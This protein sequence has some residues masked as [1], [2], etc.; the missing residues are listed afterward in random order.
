MSLHGKRVLLTGG[1][2]G[3]GRA[4]AEALLVEGARLALVG[5]NRAAL[6]SL[7][8]GRVGHAVITGD[9]ARPEH[10]VALADQ[11]LRDLGGLDAFVSAAGIVEYA[12]V[13]AIAQAAI[14]R[15]LRVNC[16]TPLLIAQ[17]LANEL[18]SGSSMLFIASTLAFAPAPMTTAYAASKA[19]LIAG[20]RTLALEL[21]P[22][23]IRANVIAPGVVDTDMVRVVRYAPGEPALN[24]ADSATRVAHQLEQ[25]R[26]LHPL[27][28]LARPE[29]VAQSALY[30]LRASYV[31][32]H[33]LVVDGG[34][35]LGSGAL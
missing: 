17:A 7:V 18:A 30:L 28:R 10:A 8:N 15:Q 12:A 14:E 35:T 32:G 13:G 19:A 1:S 16:E 26:R 33:V 23:G 4:I 3:I 31:T 24:E 22:R 2:R 29:D 20:A 25:L 27:E 11:A 6:E 5:R 9:L 34:L 21:G